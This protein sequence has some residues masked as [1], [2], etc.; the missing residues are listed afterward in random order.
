MTTDRCRKWLALAITVAACAPGWAAAAN[1]PNPVC[2]NEAEFIEQGR[3]TVSPAVFK[4]MYD[5]AAKQSFMQMFKGLFEQRK[6]VEQAALAGDAKSRAWLGVLWAQ[7]RLDGFEYSPDKLERG[8]EYLNLAQRDGD[9]EAPYLLAMYQ[10]LGWDGQ[11]ASLLRAYPLMV[12]AGRL[13]PRAQADGTVKEPS[14]HQKSRGVRTIALVELIDKRM[15]S[16]K[17]LIAPLPLGAAVTPTEAVALYSTCDKSVQLEPTPEAINREALLKVLNDIATMLP[18][19][20]LD[21]SQPGTRVPLK[22][23]AAKA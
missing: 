18:T 16:A 23:G 5:P 9:P 14:D 21:C 3:Q 13:K 10:V 17:K 2:L 8:R 19:D 22:F 1:P 12:Q 6:A 4:L 20:G 7:C 11:P 15:S